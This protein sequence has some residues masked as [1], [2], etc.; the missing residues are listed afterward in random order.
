MTL[1]GIRWNRLIQRTEAKDR[2]AKREACQHLSRGRRQPAGLTPAALAAGGARPDRSP[3]PT[4]PAGARLIMVREGAHHCSAAPGW[5]MVRCSAGWVL[6]PRDTVVSLQ[7][8]GDVTQFASHCAVLRHM[9]APVLSHDA[10]TF[11]QSMGY[12]RR[13]GRC[14][15]FRRHMTPGPNPQSGS[16]GR[17][18]GKPSHGWPAYR[19]G[20]GADYPETV[21]WVTHQSAH[22][23]MQ[24][25]HPINFWR[26]T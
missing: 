2:S 22:Q 12:T 13:H 20:C 1:Y 11:I 23:V 17:T 3:P 18:D 15:P 9:P 21:G 14:I 7:H 5:C 19:L 24:V 4:P 10:G 8:A 26:Q 6:Y 16:H 25:Y